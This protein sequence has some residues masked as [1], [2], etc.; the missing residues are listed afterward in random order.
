MDSNTAIGNV[1]YFII[2][3]Q[4]DGAEANTET[5]L[6]KNLTPNSLATYSQVNTAMRALVELS[7]NTYYDTICVTNIS[8]GEIMAG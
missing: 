5:T 6:N 3:T 2:V 1:S 7:N 8:V 4:A